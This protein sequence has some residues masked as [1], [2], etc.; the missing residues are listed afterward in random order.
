MFRINMTEL[1]GTLLEAVGYPR[2]TV[3]LKR[4]CL[5]ICTGI[6]AMLRSSMADGQCLLEGSCS[7]RAGMHDKLLCCKTDKSSSLQ[8]DLSPCIDTVYVLC[9]ECKL[10]YECHIQLVSDASSIHI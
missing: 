9:K 2:S 7:S 5:H 6:S 3:A 1:L 4:V 10:L 8:S